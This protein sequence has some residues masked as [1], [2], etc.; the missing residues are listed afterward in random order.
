[1]TPHMTKDPR[2]TILVGHDNDTGPVATAFGLRLDDLVVVFS[3]ATLDGHRD[4]GHGGALT[5]AAVAAGAAQGATVATLQSSAMGH[6]LYET[7]G[8][9][10]AA[11]YDMWVREAEG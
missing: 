6:S 10:T 3:V 11:T 8:F 1:M 5:M 4:R 9:E 2:I 7:L